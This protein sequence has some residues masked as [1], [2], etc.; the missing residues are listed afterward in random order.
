MQQKE[1]SQERHGRSKNNQDAVT[2]F[3]QAAK[4]IETKDTSDVKA[5]ISLIKTP[6]NMDETNLIPK[7]RR[8]RPSKL[9]ELHGSSQDVSEQ[10]QEEKISDTTETTLPH[11]TTV[12]KRGKGRPKKR[13]T[14]NVDAEEMNEVKTEEENQ[15]ETTTDIN[16]Q[17][18]V[19]IEKRKGRSKKLEQSKDIEQ[20]SP[21]NDHTTTSEEKSD[22]SE[23]KET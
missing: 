4:N 16:S 9:A 21:A 15:T 18:D 12:L 20:V 7:K 5:E 2:N 8:G 23:A 1:I 17:T 14:S 11:I 22:T 10:K 6:S 3:V 19:V 13:P